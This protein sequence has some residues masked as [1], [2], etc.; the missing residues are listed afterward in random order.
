M[1]RIAM[2]VAWSLGA[3]F[4]PLAAQDSPPD[5]PPTS[6]GRLIKIREEGTAKVPPDTLYLLMK[7][8]TE[9]AQLSRAIELNQKAVKGFTEALGLIGIEQPAIRQANF[10]VGRSL[11][12][13]GVSFARNLVITVA[14]IDKRPSVE[15]DRLVAKVQDFGARFGS[16]CVTCIGSG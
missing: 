12:G 3:A 11:L 16:S 8:Q 2:L 1:R 7:V 14:G 15:I 6:A 4:Y 9:A 13:S 10:V 5:S